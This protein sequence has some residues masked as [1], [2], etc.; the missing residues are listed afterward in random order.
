M[1]PGPRAPRPRSASLLPRTET[2]FRGKK[3]GCV[4]GKGLICLLLSCEISKAAG[5]ERTEQ[6]SR[7]LTHR[8]LPGTARLQ[9][10]AAN[11]D[12]Q[13]P[14][15]TRPPAAP[16]TGLRFH[17]DVN[18]ERKVKGASALYCVYILK[19]KVLYVFITLLL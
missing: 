6:Q 1:W 15:H 16:C 14:V 2:R 8:L 18:F 13:S 10:A 17:T 5:P 7:S 12:A 19:N 11:G 3:V 9:R 4:S